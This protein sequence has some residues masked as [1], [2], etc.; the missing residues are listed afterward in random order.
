M[1]TWMSQEVSKRIVNFT[2]VITITSLKIVCI[3]VITSLLTIYIHLLLSW[4]IQVLRGKN[5]IVMVM[6][7]VEGKSQSDRHI[8]Y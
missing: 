5:G 8:L 6:L 7:M 1:C 2:W 3:G 4:D